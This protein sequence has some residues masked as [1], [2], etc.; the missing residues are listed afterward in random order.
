MLTVPHGLNSSEMQL[1]PIWGPSG[2]LI[3]PT[4]RQ[5]PRVDLIAVTFT[6]GEGRGDL[7][8]KWIGQ[9]GRHSHTK[10]RGALPN[11]RSNEADSCKTR[12]DSLDE[13]CVGRL[14]WTKMQCPR[15][16]PKSFNAPSK[17]LQSACKM[18]PKIFMPRLSL[19]HYVIGPASGGKA[20]RERQAGSWA[21]C[22]PVYRA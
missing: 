7:T 6:T 11:H 16:M 22:N 2:L 13:R 14:V 5:P 15:I 1:V 12:S 4:V 10:Q 8:R 3:S 17:C 9:R 19:A 21:A 20:A 18:P